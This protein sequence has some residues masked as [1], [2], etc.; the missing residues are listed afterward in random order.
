MTAGRGE[1]AKIK[2]EHGSGGALAR[3][4]VES[5]I[6][7]HFKNDRFPELSDASSF[8]TSG[9][10]FVTT[11]TYVVDPPFFP[12]GDIGRL[13]VFGTCND[14]AVAG[15]K[16]LFLTLGFVLE[17]GFAV[18]DLERVLE[19]I[20]RAAEEAGVRI[21]SGDTKVVPEGKGGGIFINSSG[22][23]E[24]VFSHRISNTNIR[25]GDA[26]LVTG[27]I[28]SHGIAILAAREALSVG[29]NLRSDCANLYP[30][31][32]ELFSLGAELRFLRDATRGGVASILNEMA[33]GMDFGIEVREDDVPIEQN[34]AAVSEILGINPLEVANEGVA[35]AVVSGPAAER[36]CSS[37]KGHAIG[38]EAV[39]IGRVT[40]SHPGKVILLTRVGGRRLLDFPRGLLL[41][42]IC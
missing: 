18:A 22:I 30:L 8:E 42:R 41:P 5:V 27:P 13:A 7:P 39:T 25:A 38:R 35:V 24:R 28:G 32:R 17:E 36:A 16:P 31:C 9:E 3:D 37:L 10:L 12:G 23:G 15:A 20:A 34:V 2:L 21:I 1:G 19:S 26:V 11:D 6:Y 29:A 14:L 33:A 40:D 4:L